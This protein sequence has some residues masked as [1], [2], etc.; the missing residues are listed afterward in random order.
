MDTDTDILGHVPHS[1][2]L[3]NC[4]LTW[5]G[6]DTQQR[7]QQ[8]IKRAQDL[9]WHEHSITYTFNDQGWRTHTPSTVRGSGIMFLGDS[10][11]MAVG[12][13]AEQSWAYKVWQHSN[14]RCFWNLAVGGCG[15]DTQSRLF[16]YW[17]PRLRPSAV[18]ILPPIEPRREFVQDEGGFHMISVSSN[19]DMDRKAMERY[20]HWDN[21][22]EIHGLRCRAWIQSVADHNSIQ[23]HWV[24]GAKHEDRSGRDLLHPG[25]AWHLRT[26]EELTDR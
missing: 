5:W 25:P 6:T 16:W 19:D 26:A 14:T 4:T 18:Y 13:P 24:T 2:H 7:Y 1:Q 10:Y 9:G 3:K 11:T 21:E 17:A 15:M 8:N 23:V 12:V 22:Q 20:F